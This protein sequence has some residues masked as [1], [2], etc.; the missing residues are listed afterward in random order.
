LYKNLDHTIKQH[1]LNRKIQPPCAKGCASCCSQF[2][3]ISE[4][5]FHWIKSHIKNLSSEAQLTLQENANILTSL[6]KENWPAF[7]NDFFAKGHSLTHS[8]TYY[9]HPDRHIVRLPCIFLSAEGACQIYEVRPIVCR[10][11]GVG[12]Q[13]LFNTGSVCRVIKHGLLT[14]LWQAD[15]RPYLDIIDSFRWLPDN[16]EYGYKRQYPMFF[17]VHQL[18]S[19]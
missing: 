19:E 16:S 10:T 7:Y 11:T 15:L 2:F 13:Y 1:Y 5:E 3:E 12:Y 9:D 18:M 17:Y 6:F 8:E 14:P 4:I